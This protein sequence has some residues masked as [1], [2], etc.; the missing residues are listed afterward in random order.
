VRLGRRDG[1]VLAV[2]E[3]GDLILRTPAN[4]ASARRRLR[5]WGVRIIPGALPVIRRVLAAG[6]A[7]QHRVWRAARSIP[8]G[9]TRTYGMLARR[10]GCRAAQAVGSALGANPLAMI[11]P[12]HRVVGAAG[13]GGFAWGLRR[14]QAW[15]AAERRGPAR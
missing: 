3:S 12:C 2:T 14:K 6:S 7:F 10:L 5:A 8:A 9:Q 11:I 4:A 1:F 13:P 15:L